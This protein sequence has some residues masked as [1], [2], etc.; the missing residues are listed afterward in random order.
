MLCR[1]EPGRRLIQGEGARRASDWHALGDPAAAI[2]QPQVCLDCKSRKPA[3]CA[4]LSCAHGECRTHTILLADMTVLD[5]YCSLGLADM[6]EQWHCLKLRHKSG[7]RD[8]VP[9]GS[10]ADLTSSFKKRTEVAVKK[11]VTLHLLLRGWLTRT[12]LVHAG[13]RLLCTILQ[14]PPT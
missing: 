3:C 1:R 2:S 14:R 10:F 13:G 7:V 8:T 5:C 11:V 4:R 12:T 9:S 6:V